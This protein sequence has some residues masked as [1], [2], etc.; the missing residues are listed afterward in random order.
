[1]GVPRKSR[2]CRPLCPSRRTAIATVSVALHDGLLLSGEFGVARGT[3]ATIDKRCVENE[4]G[5]RQIDIGIPRILAVLTAFRDSKRL[6]WF[7]PCWMVEI[8]YLARGVGEGCICALQNAHTN[9][10]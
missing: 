4:V 8:S 6:R 9:E 1:M 3:G 10:T 5:A 2:T 7:D